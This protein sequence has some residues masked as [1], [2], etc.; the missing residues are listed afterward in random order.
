MS[1]RSTK[2][3]WLELRWPR[4]VAPE[5]LAAVFRLLNSSAGI[6]LVLEAIGSGGQVRHLLAVP[7]GSVHA[8][9]TQLQAAVSGLSLLN[10]TED[11]D[12]FEPDRALR[13]GLSTKRRPLR[14]A[15]PEQLASGLLTALAGLGRDET[16]VLQWLLGPTLPPMIVPSQMP[17]AHSDS[18]AKSFLLAPIQA[19]P[20]ADSETRTA[21]RAKQG[22]P[23]WRAI[24]RIAVKA[25]GVSRQNQLLRQ[26]LSVLRSA[27]APGVRITARLESS[28]RFQ[29][30]TLPWFWPMALNVH[31]LQ[32][33]SSWP[34]GQTGDLPVAHAGS[35]ALKAS[36]SIPSRGRLLGVSNWP[37]KERTV[38]LSTND[39]LRHLHVLGPTGT[40]KSTLLLNLI[41]QDMTAGRAVVV[42]E[43]KGD[44][45]QDV[46]SRIP[47]A[48]AA[49]IVLLDPTDEDQPVGLNP[50]RTGGRSPEL[51]AD[52]LLAVFHGLYAAHWG[53]RTQDILHASLLTLARTPGR[54]LV[55]LPLL[56]T[57]PAFRRKLVGQLNDPLALG[58]FWAGFE[59][60]SEA[61][62]TAA[63]S[64]VMNKLRPFILRSNLRRVIGQAE[65]KFDVRQVFTE[66]KILLV[67]LSKGQL[68]PEAAA[69]LG[70]LV[71]AQ[72]WQATLERSRISPE[73]RH[74]VMVF[75]DEFQDYLHLPTD[76]G[77]ALSQARGLGVGL[78][79]AHQH[80]H[81]L[82]PAMRS[83]VL[84]NA[85]SRICFQLG[86]E[87]ARTMAAGGSVLE[88]ED[89]QSLGRFEAY[90][91]LMAEDAVQPWCSL[92]TVAPGPILSDAAVIR[93]QSHQA[94]GVPR[95]ETDAALAKLV[96]G[97]RQSMVD[98][99]SPRP[100]TTGGSS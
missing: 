39:S 21:L 28:S 73:R 76:L 80:L 100:K 60:W 49:D 78:T 65:P 15:D 84:A 91:S 45:I 88:A 38:A 87:D 97:G 47:P 70:S 92:K 5:A 63:I 93:N 41:S 99:L 86:Q 17:G 59:A 27:Q 56:L 54:T 58:P 43:P 10:A 12:G 98:D 77:D 16:L 40:G 1:W 89:F 44:L 52:Q 46:L 33:L 6:P 42:I 34:V 90:A 18:W 82:E 57:N 25:A 26:V 83:A 30:V 35:R 32:V 74:P 2:M 8:V 48:R 3:S 51:V 71:V 22:E 81:Q 31:E 69:L 7:T 24:G 36:R 37:G 55:A 85:R 68:G 11:R 94:Y 19:P 14:T 64:P 96:N 95:T 13:L 61:E 29:K 23:G 53:P 50:L 4:E 79:L 75:I 20:P 9:R 67:N 66:R 62:R 72:L